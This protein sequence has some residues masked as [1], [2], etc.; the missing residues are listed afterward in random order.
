[1]NDGRHKILIVDD[2]RGTREM[3]D[4]F[5]TKYSFEVILARNGREAIAKME[6][7]TFD[8]VLM[9]AIMPEMDGITATHHIKQ[10][11]RHARTPILMFT[12]YDEPLKKREAVEAGVEEFLDKTTALSEILQR[13]RNLIKMKD[14]VSL[15]LQYQT[16]LES[17]VA[18][19]TAEL[20]FL[21][22]EKEI[23]NR[24]ILRRI[25]ITAEYRDDITGKHTERVGILSYV[26]AQ[27]MK[28]DCDFCKDLELTAPLHDVGKIGIP[29]SILLKP[30][31]LDKDE[32]NV[33]K[34]HTTL[35]SRILGG[36]NVPL[37]AKAQTIAMSHHERW[38]GNGYPSRLSGKDIPF[39]GRI[40]AI[41]DTFDTITSRRPYKEAKNPETALRIIKEERGKQFDPD[42]VDAFTQCYNAAVKILNR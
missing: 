2:E 38:D 6:D 32:W 15:K 5:F 20:K 31:K 40:V 8:A 13:I 12:G 26:I 35:G 33:M 9:D 25:A 27:T 4:E 16:K 3:L 18:V 11:P 36:S 23:L 24:E 29:D 39:E 34:T 17:E 14:Y 30:G 37:L 7:E 42:L 41:A 28:L 1:M 22:S 19:K 10:N 21:L